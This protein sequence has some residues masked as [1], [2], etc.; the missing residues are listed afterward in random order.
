MVKMNKTD[1]KYEVLSMDK[2][3]SYFLLK[4]LKENYLTPYIVCRNFEYEE[5]FSNAFWTN[6]NYFEDEEEA[7]EF[8][9]LSISNSLNH[10][11][12]NKLF[13]DIYVNA[14]YFYKFKAIC[15]Q[16][17]PYYMNLTNEEWEWLYDLF[18]NDDNITGFISEEVLD[19]LEDKL[20]EYREDD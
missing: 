18:L 6:G 1:N 9:I 11:Y 2:K 13:E 14:S 19:Y 7:R 8:F 4:N 3:S 10:K 17:R 5:G 16:E 15:L 20:Y 12:F